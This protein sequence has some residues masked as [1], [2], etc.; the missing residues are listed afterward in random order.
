MLFHDRIIDLIIN[1]KNLIY[2]K[3]GFNPDN[4]YKNKYYHLINGVNFEVDILLENIF[5]KKEV[6]I[7]VKSN[8]N[9]KLK[10][11]FYSKQLPIFRKYFPDADIYLAY[12]KYDDLRIENL[13]FEFVENLV[14]DSEY[15]KS[16]EL[17]LEE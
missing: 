16:L 3:F 1:D 13:E 14:A 12:L 17:I 10:N 6:L 8:Y 15:L 2:D 11:K 9:S 4:I 5:F 7:E